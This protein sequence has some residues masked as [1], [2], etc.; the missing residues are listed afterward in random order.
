MGGHKKRSRS[1]DH[2]SERTS[3]RLHKLEEKMEDI[4]TKF[5]AIHRAILGRNETTR[6]SESDPSDS[7]D[8][9]Q[10]A[11]PK[12]GTVE[13]VE[14]II[15]DP[16]NTGPES[17]AV[18]ADKTELTLENPKISETET[19]WV[20]DEDGLRIFGEEPARAEP[21][22]ILHSKLVESKEVG[23]SDERESLNCEKTTDETAAIETGDLSQVQPVSTPEPTISESLTLQTD[24]S[25]F[26]GRLVHF[27]EAWKSITDDS[28]VIQCVEGYK[29]PFSVAFI[30]TLSSPSLLTKSSHN[31]VTCLLAMSNLC[32]K[33]NSPDTL[34]IPIEITATDVNIVTANNA[35]TSSFTSIL[36]ILDPRY[37]ACAMG[38]N[39][40]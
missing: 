16:A 22:L 35:I 18:S 15:Q 19:P 33:A 31:N 4:A 29:I 2:S 24:V 39:E 21:E 3:K 32:I 12:S 23:T 34:K 9:V 13:E 26:A 25:I 14:E 27:V 7:E 17:L 38:C 36:Q 40:N 1:R 28:F 6:L 10:V 11:D 8:E 37:A 5:D 30:H 20:L